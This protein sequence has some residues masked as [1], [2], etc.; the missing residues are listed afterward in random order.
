VEWS[1]HA[2]R[3]G[4]PGIDTREGVEAIGYQMLKM[5][6]NAGAIALL[7][8]NA[9]DYPKSSSS[10]FALGRAYRSASDTVR[11]RAE[12]GRAIALDPS[13]KRASDALAA[14]SH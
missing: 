8:L 2:F 12:L 14:I 9:G 10:A 6:D 7:V 5:N 4:H 13:N 11:A 3:Q 1:Y